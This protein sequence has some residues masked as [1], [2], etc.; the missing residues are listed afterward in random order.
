MSSQSS[1]FN[2]FKVISVMLYDMYGENQLDITNSFLSLTIEENIF[3]KYLS[4]TFS[5]ID[6]QCLDT[7][8]PILG[9]EIIN[10]KLQDREDS[11]S[12]NE[13]I[14]SL[15]FMVNSI[16]TNPNEEI[17]SQG[18]NRTLS[19]EL[20]SQFYFIDNLRKI[21]RRFNNTVEN[22]LNYLFNDVMKM[23]DFIFLFDNFNIDFVSNFWNVST[24][25]DYICF[26]S[27][28]GFFF[29]TLRNFTFAKFSTL[30][31]QQLEEKWE[32]S[33]FKIEDS[34]NF[35]KVISCKFSSKFSMEEMFAFDVFGNTVYNPKLSEYN[36]EVLVNDI[37]KEMR[38]YER[39]GNLNFFWKF[40]N[41]YG[42]D[43]VILNSMVD[44]E[45][46][47]RRNI[48]IQNMS[49]YNVVCTLKGSFSRNVGDLIE[50]N[51]PY[52]QSNSSKSINKLFKGKW[53]ITNITHT[54]DNKGRYDQDATIIK[55]GFQS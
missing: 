35:Q 5:M 29:Q 11:I 43:M 51:M 32:M 24:I 4:A 50:F 20:K 10:F 9:G 19:L 49:N 45:T 17:T 25:L 53:L 27:I 52:I 6:T 55:T 13:S 48:I 8:F 28:D 16:I 33:Q 22:I 14:I 3:S 12:N 15:N 21:S 37:D 31:N 38:N 34:I 23:K 54:M 47:N 42:E 41:D 39:L 7:T 40:F 18:G 30:I 44:A 26:K 36:Y 46:I 1:F 2:H